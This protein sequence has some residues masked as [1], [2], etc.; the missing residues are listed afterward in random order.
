MADVASQVERLKSPNKNTRY[1]ACEML[2]VAPAITPEALEALRLA[3]HDP[4]RL[5][6]EAAQDALRVHLE[7][8]SIKPAQA[9]RPAGFWENP[10]KKALAVAL[11]FP[12]TLVVERML[13]FNQQVLPSAAWALAFMKWLALP[14]G[15]LGVWNAIFR[16][17]PPTGPAYP[18][19]P[20]L[21]SICGGWALYL[22][23]AAAVIFINS[24]RVARVI[25]FVLALL[26]LINAVGWIL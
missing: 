9:Q 23:L 1:E 16:P 14:V 7:P 4:D 19:D 2:R 26:L 15:W 8:E 3:T 18:V 20:S 6:A 13:T 10:W 24:G 17:A 12:L 22:C 25:Y 21:G 5:V 11:L